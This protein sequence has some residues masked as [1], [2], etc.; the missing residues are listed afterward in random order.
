MGEVAAAF[1]EMQQKR[2]ADE[3]VLRSARDE[4]EA[5]VDERTQDVA[6]ANRTLLEAIESISEGFS[7]YDSDDRLILC[8]SNYQTVYHSENQ[9]EPGTPFETILHEA[10]DAGIIEDAIG[11][12]E[13]WIA[14]R[15]ENR[16]NP[17]APMIQRRR[18]GQWVQL[19]ERRTDDG[20]SSRSIP[21]SHA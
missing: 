15:L 17:N 6:D 4:L 10:V 21:A 12:E 11:N 13:A 7:L 9:L 5:R 8:N 14:Q 19:T 1:N 16:R 3:K 20:A 18:N 2:Q